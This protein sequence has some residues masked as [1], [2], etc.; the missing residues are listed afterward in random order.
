MCFLWDFFSVA[1]LNDLSVNKR[2]NWKWGLNNMR[3][4]CLS[5]LQPIYAAFK[6]L[7]NEIDLLE[8]SIKRGFIRLPKF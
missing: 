3:C 2:T 6:P 4:C 1:I 5:S 8:H 7:H